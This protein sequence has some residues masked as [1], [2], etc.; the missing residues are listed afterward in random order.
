MKWKSRLVVAAFAFSLVAPPH[1]A[2]AQTIVNPPAAPA[3][4]KDKLWDYAT[5]AAGIAFAAGTGGW[6]FAGIACLK[7]LNDHF[8][9]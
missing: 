5:C 1:A 6:V 4:N 3:F 2:V 9:D 8:S 7:A